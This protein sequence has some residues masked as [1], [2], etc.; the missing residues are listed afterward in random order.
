MKTGSN[1]N[2][3]YMAISFPRLISKA[4]LLLV[5]LSVTPAW[6][7]LTGSRLP[8]SLDA[9]SSDIDRRNDRLVFRGV[10]ISQ[11][12]LGIEADEAVASTLDFANSEWLFTGNVKI[13]MNTASIEADEATM[14]FSGY[15]LLTAV[16]RG[17]PAEFRQVEADQ[18]LT[19]GHG[20]LL[21]YMADPAV[22]RLSENAWLS[23]SGKEISGNVLTY[24]LTEERVIASSSV[25][26]GERVRIL[27]T[28]E[29]MKQLSDMDLGTEPEPAPEAVDATDEQDKPEGQKPPD[30]PDHP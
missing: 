8:I 20:R 4:T 1:Y 17:Q 6:A 23:E 14:Q 9:D 13:R 21:E 19:E 2:R 12:D 16:I 26:T 5:I 15:R 11:G 22:V 10:S 18:S 3:W 27:I 24:S 25:E 7:V 28:P 29:G 30:T